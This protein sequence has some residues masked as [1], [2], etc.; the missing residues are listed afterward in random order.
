MAL[1]DPTCLYCTLPWLYLAILDSTTLSHVM[2]LL[3]STT[4]YHGSTTLYNGS[5]RLYLTLLH[6]TMAVLCSTSLYLTPL[7]PTMASSWLYLTLRHSTMAILGS[8]L[9]YYTLLD[10]YTLPW[11]YLA[12]LDSTTPLHSTMVY[13]AV[14]N[15]IKHSNIAL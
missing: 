11:L 8:T 13:L 12:I 7:H 1:L 4:L 10:C 9:L 14:L 15:C 3:G 5:T 2:A 6:S